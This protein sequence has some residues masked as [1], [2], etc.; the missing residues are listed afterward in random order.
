[1]PDDDVDPA[2]DDLDADDTANDDAS[3]SPKPEGPLDAAI[4]AHLYR[5]RKDRQMSRDDFV[6]MIRATA[7]GELWNKARLGRIERGAQRVTIT[8]LADVCAALD[9]PLGTFL[10]GAGIIEIEPSTRGWLDADTTI[11]IEDRRALL[12]MYDRAQEAKQQG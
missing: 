10:I 8:E 11:D 5:M 6:P 7:A 12:R 2:D 4:G 9:V 3:R 1:M